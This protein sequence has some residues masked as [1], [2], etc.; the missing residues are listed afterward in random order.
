MFI[1]II[2]LGVGFLAGALVGYTAESFFE[3]KDED[4]E[5]NSSLH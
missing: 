2:S 1:S 3:D 5:E 4:G